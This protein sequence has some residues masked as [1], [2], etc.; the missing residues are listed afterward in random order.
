MIKKAALAAPKAVAAKTVRAPVV[1]K[2]PS[3]I[4]AATP[5]PAPSAL[6]D[7]ARPSSYSTTPIDGAAVPAA[8]AASPVVEHGKMP[9]EID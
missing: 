8:P 7:E 5:V 9:G 2:A 1:A 4:V 6:S 3:T